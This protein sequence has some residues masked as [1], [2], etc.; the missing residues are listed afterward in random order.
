MNRLACAPEAQHFGPR[1]IERDATGA[2]FLV[3][4]IL[5]FV[6]LMRVGSSLHTKIRKRICAGQLERNL[7]IYAIPAPL[8]AW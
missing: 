7:M 4:S 6:F 3:K 8:S 2:D 5:V 1:S